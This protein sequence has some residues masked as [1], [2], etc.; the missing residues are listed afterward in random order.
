MY[1]CF[2]LDTSFARSTHSFKFLS[3]PLDNYIINWSS[4]AKCEAS[5]TLPAPLP[6]FGR[7]R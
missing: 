7:H 2:A 1:T 5:I 6:L 4:S 3:I